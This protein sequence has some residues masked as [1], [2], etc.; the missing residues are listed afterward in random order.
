MMDE[1]RQMA[2]IV[3]R[4]RISWQPFVP[5]RLDISLS[6][7]VALNHPWIAFDGLLG[8]LSLRRILGHEYYLLPAKYPIGRLLKGHTSG[9]LPIK[10]TNGLW[11][12]SVSWFSRSNIYVEHVYKRFEDRHYCGHGKIYTGMGYFRSHMLH[13]PYITADKCTFWFCGDPNGVADLLSELIGLGNDTRIGWGAI[14]SW[15]I[16]VQDDDESIVSKDGIAMRPIPTK[17]LKSYD[18][19]A[20]LAWRPPYWAPESVEMCAPP[21]AKVELANL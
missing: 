13:E 16:T 12:A 5:C 4:H 11:H 18:D 9:V 8:H 21:G 15:Q 3:R 2:E 1:V 20:A 14:R 19:S 17:M 6:A 10:R 7:P